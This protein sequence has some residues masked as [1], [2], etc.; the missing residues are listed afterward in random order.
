MVEEGDRLRL[1][2]EETAKIRVA[3]QAREDLLENDGLSETLRPRALGPI[4]LCHASA[5]E[6][7]LE[8]V[9]PEDLGEGRP[10]HLLGD[11]LEERVGRPAVFRWGLLWPVG[12]PGPHLG[13]RVCAGHGYPMRGSD[14][15][16]GARPTEPRKE[17]G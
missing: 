11:G 4:D 14:T 12:D 10:G 1:F 9:R 15:T 7:L 17:P 3:G 5:R 8:Q 6:H 2:D 16:R 13:K